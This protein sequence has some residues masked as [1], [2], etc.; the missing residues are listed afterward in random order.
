[1]DWYIARTLS[2]LSNALSISGVKDRI[3]TVFGLSAYASP[4]PV[5]CCCLF[6]L[7]LFSGNDPEK[8]WFVATGR[9]ETGEGAGPSNRGVSPALPAL[10]VLAVVSPEGMFDGDNAE[11]EAILMLT[12]LLLSNLAC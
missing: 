8:W 1:V 10:P 9:E 6:P 12:F 3:S 11:D 4:V 5:D 2:S 7:S